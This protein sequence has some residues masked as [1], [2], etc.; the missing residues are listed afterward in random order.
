MSVPLGTIADLGAEL[1]TVMRLQASSLYAWGIISPDGAWLD[2]TP[3]NLRAS[4]LAH[5]LWPASYEMR[6]WSTDPWLA[7]RRDDVVAD[8]FMFASPGQAGRFFTEASGTRCHRDGSERSTSRPLQGRDLTWVNPDGVAQ[9]DVFLLRG[10]RVYRV[11]VVRPRARLT[12]ALERQAGAAIANALVCS[13]PS[14]GCRRSS[15]AS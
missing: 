14:A 11:A 2:N 10:A 8:V 3:L 5:G 7:P 9:E 6:T 1:R 12:G 13:L 4:E 15:A